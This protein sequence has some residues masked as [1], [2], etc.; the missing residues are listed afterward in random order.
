M[1]VRG[2]QVIQHAKIRGPKWHNM[3]S[4]R[5]KVTLGW[6]ATSASGLSKPSFEW[7]DQVTVPVF[8]F[9]GV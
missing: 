7:T 6:H 4:L 1:K 3:A 2:T 9:F 5:T 8:L